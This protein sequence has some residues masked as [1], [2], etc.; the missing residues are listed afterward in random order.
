DNLSLLPRAVCLSQHLLS[1]EFK[2]LLGESS[3][4][5]T[6]I[7][8][9]EESPSHTKGEKD[10]KISKEKVVNEPEKEPEVE[11]I[12]K[13]RVQ[14]PQDTEPI[15]ITL[16]KPIPDMGNDIATDTDE[17]P[18]KLVKAL[19]KVHLDPDTPSLIPFEINSKLYHLINE[20][21]HAYYEMEGRKEKAA[22]EAKLLEMNKSK[23]IKVVHKE[24]TKAGVDPKVLSSAK[25]GQEFVKIQDAEMKVLKRERLEK[26]T[27]AKEPRK[28]RIDQH[29]WTT[30]SPIIQK[31]KNKV[32]GELMTSLGKKY[33]RLKVTPEKLGIN[34]TLHA[35]KGSIKNWNLRFVFME[36]NAT[37]AFLKEYHLSR[38]W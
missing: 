12:E 16:V 21:I 3:A 11:N 15:P 33:D 5:T 20:E 17:S 23:L 29:K 22:Q 25:G 37:E 18:P 32:V 19:I 36:L 31:K 28:K 14:E 8:P 2:Q 34:P 1:L 6:T 7:S 30:S 27:R 10:N 38:T 9:T 4:H 26:I 13:E 24:A 35:N